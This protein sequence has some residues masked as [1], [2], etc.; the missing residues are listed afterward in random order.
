[1]NVVKVM[2][3]TRLDRVFHPSDFTPDSDIAFEH[4]LKIALKCKSG[5]QMMHVD[6]KNDADWDYFPSVED[7]LE[8]WGILPKGSSDEDVHDL[9]LSVSKVISPN[10][11]PVRACLEF[12]EVNEVDLIV[13]SVHQRDGLMRWLGPMV[14]ERIAAG[15][16]Q[17]TLFI[18]AGSKGF[19]SSK[20]GSVNLR[21]ILV[22]IV[23][24]P[25]PEA[26]IRFVQL[27]I[28]SLGLTSGVV[29]LLHVGTSE[30]LPFVKHPIDGRWIWNRV[31][32]EGDR[33]ESILQTAKSTNADLIVM[34]TDGPDRFLDGL[35]GT[36]SE[37]VLR[38]AN[39]PVVVIPIESSNSLPI[40]G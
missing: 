31:C 27:L 13:L 7:T 23:K 24:K 14:G 17:N 15:A 8:R 16:K 18:P 30:T 11:D 3:P 28:E 37:R 21:N 33:T 2:P 29:T 6:T 10:R 9:G 38:K 26:S 34:T 19:V 36:T 1:M 40:S 32:F 20:D 4:A 12:F 25:R 22:P 5:L 35:R 39:C